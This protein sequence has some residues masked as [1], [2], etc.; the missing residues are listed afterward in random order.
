MNLFLLIAATCRFNSAAI[1]SDLHRLNPLSPRRYSSFSPQ[2]LKTK[3][4]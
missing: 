1:L 4:I 2:K 3:Q